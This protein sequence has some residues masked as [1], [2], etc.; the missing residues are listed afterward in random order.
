MTPDEATLSF[1]IG[2]DRLLGLASARLRAEDRDALSSFVAQIAVA[3]AHRQLRAQADEAA[4]LAKANEVRTAL[5]VAV[6]HDLRTPLAS[7]K[8]A[9]TSFLP[10]D[11]AW[12]PRAVRA[13][14]ETIDTE[15][16]RLSAL[17]ANLLDMS[18]LHTG[19]LVVRLEPVGLDEVVAAALISLPATGH[20]VEIDVP[21]SLAAAAA[22]PPLL[23][24]ALANLLANALGVSNPDTPLRVMAGHQPGGWVE[25]RIMDRGPGIAPAD[26]ERIFLPFQRLGDRGSGNG[27]GLGLAVAKGFVEAMG[28]ELLYED[29]PGGGATMIVRLRA[30]DTSLGHTD[31]ELPPATPEVNGDTD[32]ARG[33]VA[34]TGKLP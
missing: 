23:E 6:S 15:T 31:V 10:D 26:R 21:E 4:A 20:R 18:R 25:L 1:P 7:I 5:L 32:H 2:A 13:L 19:A 27:V 11:V 33:P 3:L 12:E 30:A 34:P 28:G 8:A 9:A 14:L 22:D 16:D 29:T 17:V 24:R